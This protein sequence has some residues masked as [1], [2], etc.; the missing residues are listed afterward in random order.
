M[1]VVIQRMVQT[2]YPGKWDELEKID[3]KFNEIEKKY[4][5]P[6]NKKR[7][8]CLF[9]AVGFNSIIIEFEWPSLSKMEKTMTKAYLDPEYQ[10]LTEKL[11]SIIMEQ[12]TE[13]YTPVINI[14]DLQ[15]Q[16]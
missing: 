8:R 11:N 16:E 12:T 4:G 5:F 2:L 6:Q 9:W 3:E 15:E 10:K 7:L 1:V 14:K 13:L